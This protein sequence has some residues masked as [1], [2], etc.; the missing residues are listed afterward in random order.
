M[1][2]TVGNLIQKISRKN[3]ATFMAG[4]SAAAAE[5]FTVMLKGIVDVDKLTAGVAVNKT[6][7]ELILVPLKILQVPKMKQQPQKKLYSTENKPMMR[8]RCSAQGKLRIY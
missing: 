6:V 7:I 4:I 8:S 3:L 2:R 5:E 1:Y